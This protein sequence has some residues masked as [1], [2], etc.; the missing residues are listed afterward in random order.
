METTAWNAYIAGFFD[1]EGSVSIARQRANG[2]ADYHKV[3][4]TLSQRAKH[5]DVLD[6]V[7]SDY[8]GRV[9]VVSQKTRVSQNW[10]E[11]AKWQ[12]QAKSEIERF[13]SAIEPYVIVKREQVRLGLE[14]IR[15]FAT[16][17]ALR[18]SAGRIQGKILPVEEI[19]RREQLRLQM[20]EA[21]KLGPQRAKPSQLPPL[22]LEHRLKASAET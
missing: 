18:D 16:G 10:A 1:G 14:F 11:N 6:R 9:L 4:V 2:K 19:G 5:R 17:A 22:S 8:G 7:A 12:L 21:N 3:I 15:S 13:L 20:L